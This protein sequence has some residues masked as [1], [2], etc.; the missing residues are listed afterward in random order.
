MACASE[1]R[2]ETSITK[3]LEQP[4]ALRCITDDNILR[5]RIRNGT[6]IRNICGIQAVIR[7]TR[8]SRRAWRDHVNR[9][10]DNRLAKI[11][12]IGKP[13]IWTVFETLLRKLSTN[14]TGKQD[15]R[16]KEKIS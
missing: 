16:I 14:I 3:R 15:Y 7:W 4:G 11:A 13:N 8:I 5:D 9:M 12:K 1:T 6:D 10:N 2:A